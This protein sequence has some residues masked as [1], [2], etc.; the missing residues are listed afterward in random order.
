MVK[1]NLLILTSVIFVIV[2]VV[3]SITTITNDYNREMSQFISIEKGHLKE[4]NKKIEYRKLPDDC[5]S[6]L[7]NEYCIC[8]S[9]VDETKNE[10]TQYP[11]L[12]ETIFLYNLKNGSKEKI[13]KLEKGHNSIKYILENNH[14]Y[15]I[16]HYVKRES[17]V[18]GNWKIQDY[19][20]ETKEIK[21]V[22]E[23][24]FE[25]FEKYEYE[26]I[27]F[28]EADMLYPMN[29][30]VSDDNMVYNRIRE[31]NGTLV[32]EIVLYNIEDSCFSVIAKGKNYRNEYLYDVAIS[33]D[34][35]VYSK[36]YEKNDDKY[37]RPTIYKY[38]D[39]FMYDLKTKKET[40]L[41]EK[42]FL[43]NIDIV[44][45]Y[46]VAA[47]V[48]EG[49]KGQ[50]VFARMQLVTRENAEEKWKIVL[51]Y[52]APIYNNLKDLNIGN[53]TFSSK[54]LIWQDNTVQDNMYV[55]NYIENDFIKIPTPYLDS[56]FSIV[57]VA[58]NSLFVLETRKDSTSCMYSV[59]IE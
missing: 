3:I 31:E 59:I 36:Y 28:A 52:K 17:N 15:W 34:M 51:D 38:C 32:F 2:M 55:Y 27:N 46:I 21:T 42:E 1:K 16:E 7:N 19:N 14:I 11:E 13:T 33:K 30:D 44:D 39:L 50:D 24:S 49:E 43:I 4:Y 37:F 20:M 53:P 48:P 57:G 5:V 9:A 22:D 40:R 47:R 23:G 8:K 45:G 25:N 6:I 12:R 54:Y 58:E 18:S 29:I 10:I 35:V 56:E 26:D 41:S